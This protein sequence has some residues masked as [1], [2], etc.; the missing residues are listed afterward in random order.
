MKF[1]SLFGPSSAAGDFGP[2]SEADETASMSANM[3]P[4]ALPANSRPRSTTRLGLLTATFRPCKFKPFAPSH[5]PTMPTFYEVIRQCNKFERDVGGL[6]EFRLLDNVGPVGYMLPEFV[7]SMVWEGTGFRVSKSERRVHLALDL[8][9]G[10]DVVEMCR[11]EFVSLCEKNAGVVGGLKKWLGKRADFHPIRGLDGHL[12]GLQMP[13]PLRGV[14]GIVTSGVHMNMYTI[15]KVHGRPKMHIWVSRRSEN[16]TYAGKLDQVVAG[17]MDPVDDMDPLKT[18]RREAMEEARLAVDIASRRVTADGSVVGMV[19]CGRRISFYDRK[20]PT[21]GSEQG[22]L[23][24]GIR[25][26]F[27]LEVDASFMPRPGEPEA[28]ADFVLKAVEDVKRDL[29]CAEW[30]PN[31]GLVMLD[32]LLRKGQIRPEDDERYGQLK[33]GLQRELPFDRM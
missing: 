14:F 23:E 3:T 20:D 26:T 15:K 12:T 2:S 1:D 29:M 22:Q 11:Q 27:D 9:N 6:W 28:V 30:K 33:Q 19:E 32:F 4:L 16:V 31:C 8:G 10:D 21:A 25:F 18:L 7:A 17:A 5:M 13:S 24:P